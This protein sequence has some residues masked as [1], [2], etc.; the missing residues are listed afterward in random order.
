MLH[1]AISARVWHCSIYI[2]SHLHIIILQGALYSRNN[3]RDCNRISMGVGGDEM[4]T[5]KI[6]GRSP[7][8]TLE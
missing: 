5:P 2:N 8:T 1:L 4:T 7:A 6:P 3:A